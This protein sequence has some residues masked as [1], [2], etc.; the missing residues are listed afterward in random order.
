[1]SIHPKN[2]IEAAVEKAQDAFWATIAAAFPTATAGDFPPDADLAFSQACVQAATVWTDLN[3]P[4][5]GWV[6]G[7]WLFNPEDGGS[8]W[9]IYEASRLGHPW[10]GWATPSFSRKVV[11][12]IVAFQ[13]R[14]MAGPSMEGT[15]LV[16]LD[17]TRLVAV[18]PDAVEDTFIIEPDAEGLYTIDLGWC[19]WRADDKWLNPEDDPP[20]I[21]RRVH[22]NG[23]VEER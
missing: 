4:S 5:R 3:V 18:N 13:K 1:V 16:W 7:E 20:V 22:A 8:G 17:D 23:H 2:T 11:D 6:T 14:H 19:W 12:E 9:T 21:E 15:H 10:N